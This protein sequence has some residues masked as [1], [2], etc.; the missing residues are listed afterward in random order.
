[1]TGEQSTIVAWHRSSRV[2]VAVFRSSLM[3]T[4]NSILFTI[5]HPPSWKP[6]TF[7]QSLRRGDAQ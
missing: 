2:D 7:N 1:M 6:Q 3:L 4:F 5:T